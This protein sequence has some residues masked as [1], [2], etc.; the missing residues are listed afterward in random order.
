[1]KV[2]LVFVSGLAA[3]S[4]GSVAWG[5]SGHHGGGSRA[6]Y[7]TSTSVSGTVLDVQSQ[8]SRLILN[9]RLAGGHLRTISFDKGARITTV[10]GSA[11][12]STDIRL[13]DRLTVRGKSSIED[14]S[15]KAVTLQGIVSVASLIATNPM[16]VEISS[17]W[18]IVVD[19]QVGTR[20]TDALH[21]TSTVAEIQDADEVKLRGIYDSSLSEM[22]QTA[23]IVRTGPYHRKQGQA[24]K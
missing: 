24:S 14:M 4:A 5:F 8:Q 7:A 6:A 3:L 21:E 13:G 17:G 9:L 16:T 22:T 18:T 20:Y 10:N 11:L 1:M 23:S 15:Q 19:T 2:L 12:P